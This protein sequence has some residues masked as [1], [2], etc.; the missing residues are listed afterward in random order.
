MTFADYCNGLEKHGKK[1]I[2]LLPLLIAFS[3]TGVVLSR[4]NT[5][6]ALFAPKES[7]FQDAG[8][9]MDEQFGD[10]SQMIMLVS[11]EDRIGT[12][13]KILDFA[14]EAGKQAGVSRIMSPFPT[15]LSGKTDKEIEAQ[16][17]MLDRIADNGIKV[18][19]ENNGVYSFL[20]RIQLD[21][22]QTFRK[23]ISEFRPL[24]DEYFRDYALSGEPYLESAIFS[25]ILRILIF[26]PPLA[27]M[28]MLL[29]FRSRIGSFRATLL[30]M[31]PA[32]LSAI[33]GLGAVCWIEKNISIMSVL[34]PIFIIVLGSADGLHITSHVMDLRREG[35]DNKEAIAKTLKAVGIP[36]ILTTL[37]TM[38]G[39]LSLLTIKSGAISEMAITATGG[40]FLAGITTWVVLPAI[41]LHQKPL[42]SR[43]ETHSGRLTGFFVR[44]R[45]PRAI[46]LSVLVLAL[47]VPGLFMV[48][49]DFSMNDLYKKN[50][51]VRKSIGKITEISGGAFPIM[52]LAETDDYLDPAVAE[53]V[54]AFQDRIEQEGLSAGSISIYRMIRNFAAIQTKKNAYPPIKSLALRITGSLQR[55]NGVLFDNLVAG[56]GW[57]RIMLYAESIDTN[58]L[59]RISG[60]AQEFSSP[61]LLTLHPAGTAF[62]MMNMNRIIIPQQLQS[63]LIALAAVLVLTSLFTRKIMAGI[64]ALVPIM[65]SLCGL[66]G[67]M[68]YASIDI[69]IIT[70]IMSG[71]A[72]GVGIDYA[73][74]YIS[75]Y[76]FFKKQDVADPS[77]EAVR[78]VA[79]PVLA[80]ALGLAIGFSVML[81]SPLQI[82]TTLSILFWV[83]MMLSA[84]LGL[85]LLPTLTGKRKQK[86]AG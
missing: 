14:D 4:I 80:N 18:I 67:V 84:F 28:L 75:L 13:R 41:L 30:S 11:S 71:L 77:G 36:I 2:V 50:T 64:L 53:K 85:S 12:I 49:S 62:E 45:G 76:Y 1:I 7:R 65:I 82:H 35:A 72:I 59:H 69:S 70:S 74:H 21:S 9:L 39:F 20:L 32:V 40:I 22:G 26:L 5:D 46:A 25:Y 58:A 38:A 31:V 86:N 6:F 8:K 33:I 66:F 37:T 24:A 83:S 27:I 17:A 51:E 60:L 52:L 73:V 68:G 15:S 79:T 29:V 55:Q 10:S 54:L 3:V 61:G 23:S 81:F 56:N 44:I 43:K 34:I 78:Y 57:T 42:K 19:Y 16:L 48:R 47:T 63:I